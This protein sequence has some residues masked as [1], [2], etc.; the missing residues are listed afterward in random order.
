M[1][2]QVTSAQALAD[3][4]TAVAAQTAAITSL[5]TVDTQIDAAVLAIGAKLANAG[6]AP[7]DIEAALAPLSA[8]QTTLAQITTDLTNQ[9]NTLN[10]PATSNAQAA[11]KV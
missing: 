6:V 9:A 4:Q 2:T 8:A 5:Q 3:L 1:G 11:K 7:A 10:P